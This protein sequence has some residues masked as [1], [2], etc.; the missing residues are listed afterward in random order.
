MNKELK[1]FVK[2]PSSYQE[3]IKLQEEVDSLAKLKRV[4]WVDNNTQLVRLE[5]QIFNADNGLITDI[6][7]GYEFTRRELFGEVS[8]CFKLN[9][10]NLLHSV[11]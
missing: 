8:G 9:V 4:N 1:P 5:V 2:S 10:L 6:N 7:L 11:K 3:V